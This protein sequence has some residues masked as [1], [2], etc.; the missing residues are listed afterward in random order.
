MRLTTVRDP[1][2]PDPSYQWLTSA[3]PASAASR[4]QHHPPARGAQADARAYQAQV[5][6]GGQLR[7][8]LRPVQVDAAGPHRACAS[9]FT[10]VRP[11]AHLALSRQV[12]RITNDFTVQVYEIHAR[13]ALEKVMPPHAGPSCRR[14]SLIRGC[15][16]RATS[17]SS[18]SASLACISCIASAS[19]AILKSSSATA[20]STSFSPA[21]APVRPRPPCVALPPVLN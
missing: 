4:S 7:V 19:A 15:T 18:T 6:R 1:L 12:Q 21:T 2:Y 5:A 9:F 10:D 13:I 8:H 14:N 3:H 11:F 17:A 20:F 16:T